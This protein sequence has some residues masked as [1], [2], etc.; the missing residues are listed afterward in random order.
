MACSSLARRLQITLT[1][2]QTKGRSLRQTRPLL[3]DL[4]AALMR[5]ELTAILLKAIR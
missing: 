2:S 3:S 4:V 5:D 1:I